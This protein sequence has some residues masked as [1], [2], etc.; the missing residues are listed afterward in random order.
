MYKQIFSSI[1]I[2]ILSLNFAYGQELTPGQMEEMMALAQP[3]PEHKMLEKMVGTWEQTV[4][5]WMKPGTEPAEMKGKAVNKM[6]LGGRFLQ[7]NMSGGE[8]EMK[9]EG[10]NLMGYDRR[11]KHFTTVGFDTW[12]T[13]YVTAAGQYDEKTKS[14]VMYGEDEEP[15]AG[16]TQKYDIIVRFI[17]DDTF[18]SEIVFKDERTPNQEE[19][20][21]VEVTNKRVK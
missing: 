14:I 2:I 8:G 10:L 17:D 21:M 15:T 12:G 20:K 3:G 11:H 1:C 6:I 7:S 16:I 5:F 9:M 13:Y 19:F 4:K 18:V